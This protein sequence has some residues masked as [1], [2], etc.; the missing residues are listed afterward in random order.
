M[1]ETTPRGYSS[2]SQKKVLIPTLRAYN[3]KKCKTA[4]KTRLEAQDYREPFRVLKG[5]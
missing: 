1:L 5:L 4:L 2:K 3:P